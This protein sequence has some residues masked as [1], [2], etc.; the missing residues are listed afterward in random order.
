MNLICLDLATCYGYAILHNGKVVSGSRRLPGDHLTDG[1][2]MLDYA[3]WLADQIRFFEPDNVVFESPYVSHTPGRQTSQ[4][5]VLTLFYL[6]A[7]T[8]LICAQM[9]VPC[10]SLR[11]GDWRKSFLGADNTT[12]RKKLKDLVMRHCLLRGLRPKDDNEADALG[13]LEYAAFR[14][15]VRPPWEIGLLN[16]S[17]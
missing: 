10:Y 16:D 4:R 7:T 15:G 9:Q 12:G 8:E 14:F 11:P 1:R 3:N 13:V 5:T 2:R 17:R 6:A